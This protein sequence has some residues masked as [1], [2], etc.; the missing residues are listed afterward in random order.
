MVRYIVPDKPFRWAETSGGVPN[1]DK[2]GD[3]GNAQQH[4]PYLS[5]NRPMFRLDS[6]VNGLSEEPLT[7]DSLVGHGQSAQAVPWYR[8]RTKV[9]AALVV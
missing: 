2:N 7:L 9:T 6:G 4:E 1:V 8:W 3:E 5:V